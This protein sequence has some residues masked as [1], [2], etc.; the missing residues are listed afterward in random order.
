MGKL[1][2]RVTE[3]RGEV[4]GEE[5]LREFWATGTEGGTT[6]KRRSTGEIKHHMCQKE[7]GE[8]GFQGREQRL[9]KAIKVGEVIAP[10]CVSTQTSSLCSLWA[11]SAWK[12]SYDSSRLKNLTHLLKYQRDLGDNAQSGTH[13][14]TSVSPSKKSELISYSTLQMTTR[15][16]GLLF[17][18]KKFCGSRSGFFPVEDSTFTWRPFK[19][20]AYWMQNTVVQHERGKFFDQPWAAWKQNYFPSQITDALGTE[21]DGRG[22]MLQTLNKRER[23]SYTSAAFS[24]WHM[25]TDSRSV[26]ISI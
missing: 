21:T 12:L 20:N 16:S 18:G 25:E 24:C 4:M 13:T 14:H 10:V 5:V 1:E 6:E 26:H 2:W 17:W 11:V 9:G 3:D 7:R 8:K 19:D 22:V 15:I 23:E